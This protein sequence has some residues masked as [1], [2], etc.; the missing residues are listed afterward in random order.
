MLASATGRQVTVAIERLSVADQGY[1]A[2]LK[3]HSAA[4]LAEEF[5]GKVIEVRDGDTL[6][7]LVEGQ[8]FEVSLQG[9]EA[10]ELDQ[11]CGPKSRE[12]LARLVLGQEVHGRLSGN[13]QDSDRACQLWVKGN[14]T[15]LSKPML[16]SGLAWRNQLANSS[17]EFQHAQIEAKMSRIGF[18][19][20]AD[21]LAPWE[22]RDLSELQREQFRKQ[23]AEKASQLAVEK[24]AKPQPKT[25]PKEVLSIRPSNS[26]VKQ[27]VSNRYFAMVQQ[28][29]AAYWLN[30][31]SGVRWNAPI[32]DPVVMRVRFG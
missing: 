19:A 13:R 27:Q 7:I 20:A 28:R 11:D 15:E 14:R 8:Q 16:Q 6:S 9:I 10:P 2:G 30:T 22:W 29:W 1:L 24:A 21:Q 18:W 25:K 5:D 12:K 4:E 3:P 32:L 26:V 31:D 17:R 23:L